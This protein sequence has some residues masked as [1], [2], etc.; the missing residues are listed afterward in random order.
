[1]YK[2][3]VPIMSKNIKRNNRD[4]LLDE[5][6]RFDTGRVFLALDKYETDILKKEIALK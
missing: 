4:R 3:S 5:L 1:M 6:K 2:I